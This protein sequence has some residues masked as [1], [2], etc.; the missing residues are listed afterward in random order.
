MADVVGVL[1]VRV[2]LVNP[3]ALQQYHDALQ[4]VREAASDMEWRTDLKEAVKLL[5]SA[6]QEFTTE[7]EG[8]GNGV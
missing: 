7:P 4:L 3:E 1:T 2:M 5:T 6:A 8:W